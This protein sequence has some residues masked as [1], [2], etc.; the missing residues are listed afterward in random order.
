MRKW[1]RRLFGDLESQSYHD[2]A[3]RNAISGKSPS[4]R[5]L[6]RPA[7]RR[8]FQSDDFFLFCFINNK[9]QNNLNLFVCLRSSPTS[10]N[11]RKKKKIGKYS[12]GLSKNCVRKHF[13]TYRI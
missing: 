7:Q 1:A 3:L 9:Q 5:A 8:M 4:A 11:R 10:W 6:L 2:Y 12:M 13:P